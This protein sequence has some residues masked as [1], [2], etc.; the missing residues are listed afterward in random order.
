M[1]CRAPVQII[2][3]AC[4]EALVSAFQHIDNPGH[5]SLFSSASLYAPRHGTGG[6][7]GVHVRVQFASAGNGVKADSMLP[8]SVPYLNGIR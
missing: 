8:A 3:D 4:I 5:N 7:P 2:G 1:R 6:E